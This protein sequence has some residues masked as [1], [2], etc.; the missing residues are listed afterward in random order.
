VPRGRRVRRVVRRVD[1]WSVL[2]V[3][4]FFYLSM[5]IV[6]LIGAIILWS[7]AQSSGAVGK[8]EKFM[9]DLGFTE[10]RFRG[11]QI[12]KV[13]LIGGI[14][15]MIAGTVFTTIMAFLYNLIS[16]LVGGIEFQVI[17]EEAVYQGSAPGGPGGGPPGAKQAGRRGR[18]GRRRQPAPPGATQPLPRR[19]VV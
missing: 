7:L 16:D 14:I 10:F 3:S 11:D 2:K 9:R 1:P 8:I 17:E 19:T 13:T 12:F 6:L 4:I 18:S 5:V 15:L